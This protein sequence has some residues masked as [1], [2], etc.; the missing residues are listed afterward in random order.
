MAVEYFEITPHDFV[1]RQNDAMKLALRVMVEEGDIPREVASKYIDNWT[2]VAIRKCSLLD[3]LKGI[4]FK[5]EAPEDA[6]VFSFVEI[7]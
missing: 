4:L 6:F 7:K 2:F 5:P 1:K 3:R